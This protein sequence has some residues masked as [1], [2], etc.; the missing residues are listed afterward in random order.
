M[1]RGQSHAIT[2][3]RLRELVALGWHVAVICQA[4]AEQR[5]NAWHGEWTVRAVR[6]DGA[7]ERPLVVHRPPQNERRIK[8]LTAVVVLLKELGFDQANIPLVRGHRSIHVPNVRW[9]SPATG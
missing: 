9:E 8:T 3:H 1:D 6:P 7:D 5:Y 2:E 4:A